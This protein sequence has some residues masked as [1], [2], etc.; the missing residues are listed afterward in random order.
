MKITCCG[1]AIACT[2]RWWITLP[3]RPD[4]T[5]V[6]RVLAGILEGLERQRK[7]AIVDSAEHHHDLRED[8]MFGDFHHAS[9]PRWNDNVTPIA[10]FTIDA[11]DQDRVAHVIGCV[12]GRLHDDAAELARR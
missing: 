6:G 4:T 3:C 10:L 12:G 1:R 9:H 5:G 7:L 11:G 2:S 8:L